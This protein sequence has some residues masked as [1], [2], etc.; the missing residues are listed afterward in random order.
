MDLE[1]CREVAAKQNYKR[2]TTC[3]S[4]LLASGPHT[5]LVF[6]LPLWSFLLGLFAGWLLLFCRPP[7][8]GGP[9]ALSCAV[10]S[11]YVSSLSR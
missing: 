11:P 9:S 7:D 6:L 4:L 3:T 10:S 5:A 1:R 2:K 8:V